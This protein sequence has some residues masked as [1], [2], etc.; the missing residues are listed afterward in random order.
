M[1]KVKVKIPLVEV[2]ENMK[3]ELQKNPL[4]EALDK[5]T[6]LLKKKK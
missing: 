1:K 5:I 6:A 4:K 3:G 2:R